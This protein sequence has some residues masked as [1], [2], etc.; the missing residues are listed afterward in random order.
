[1]Y[2]WLCARAHTHT[3]THMVLHTHTHTHT[4]ITHANQGNIVEVLERI[5]QELSLQANIYIYI[6]S[7]RINQKLSIEEK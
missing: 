3:H 1:M 4:H 2:L 6:G 7:L 5:N